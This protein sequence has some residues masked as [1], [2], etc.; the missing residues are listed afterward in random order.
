MFGDG[1]HAGRPV[2]GGG[3]QPGITSQLTEPVERGLGFGE[4]GFEIDNVGGELLAGISRHVQLW[5]NIAAI[6]MAGG[7]EFKTS[8]FPYIL[9]GVSLLGISSANCPMPLR[10]AVWNRLG[11]DMKPAALASVVNRVVPLREV[12]AAC[13][14]LMARQ[15]FGRILVDCA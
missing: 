10:T 4:S 9:R 15:S 12:I 8:V 3:T 5:G 2:N 6:G 11:D 1:E 13:E 14:P 7:H